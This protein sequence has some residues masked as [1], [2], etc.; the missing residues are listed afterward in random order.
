MKEVI[1]REAVYHCHK[2]STSESG[3]PFLEAVIQACP[4]ICQE[5]LNSILANENMNLT[6]FA[7]H[8]FA[9]YV[10]EELAKNNENCCEQISENREMFE[11]DSFKI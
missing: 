2:L 5:I 7:K 4:E 10:L 8:E 1:S 6:N 11:S 9:K 3:S